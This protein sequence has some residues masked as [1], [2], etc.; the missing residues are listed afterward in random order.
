M[1]SRLFRATPQQEIRPAD[2]SKT[3]QPARA[4]GTHRANQPDLSNATQTTQ[5][6]PES[7]IR[8]PQATRV[9]L[10]EPYGMRPSRHNRSWSNGH[11][12]ASSVVTT[13]V[14]RMIKPLNFAFLELTRVLSQPPKPQTGVRTFTTLAT[15]SSTF[16]S[17]NRPL[18]V[19]RMTMIGG[20]LQ[21]NH[22]GLRRGDLGHVGPLFRIGSDGAEGGCDGLCRSSH[23]RPSSGLSEFPC[24]GSIYALRSS[25]S[26]GIDGGRPVGVS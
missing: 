18:S 1:C 16:A 23:N 26:G 9:G 6:P 11:L 2:N 19:T 25:S 17:R 13:A 8:H 7:L 24:T 14:P 21:R 20:R 3:S 10:S 15:R 5:R 4:A 22:H 12:G